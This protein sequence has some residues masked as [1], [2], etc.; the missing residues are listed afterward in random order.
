MNQLPGSTIEQT[1]QPAPTQ[2]NNSLEAINPLPIVPLIQNQQNVIPAQ[3][4]VNPPE[5]ALDPS[6]I[7][8]LI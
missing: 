7:I 4:E 8:I 1:V 2:I 3:M 5:P 6:K